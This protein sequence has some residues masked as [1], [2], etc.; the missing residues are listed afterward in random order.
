LAADDIITDIDYNPNRKEFAY[1]SADRMIYL[2][3]FSPRG[4]EMPLQAVLQGQEE[5]VRQVNDFSF[6]LKKKKNI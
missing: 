6:F 1:S 2:R 3:K 4:D 5:E